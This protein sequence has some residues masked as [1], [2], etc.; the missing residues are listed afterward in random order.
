MLKKTADSSGI[1]FKLEIDEVDG[2]FEKESEINLYRIVQESVGNILKHAQAT[3]ARVALKKDER[4]V[5]ISI[6]DNG[7]GFHPEAATFGDPGR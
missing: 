1:I 5:E 4:T 6:Q 2:A 7:K 3:E